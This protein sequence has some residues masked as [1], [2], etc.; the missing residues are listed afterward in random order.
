V[1]SWAYVK[2]L[3]VKG[4][5]TCRPFSLP[6]ELNR[7]FSAVIVFQRRFVLRARALPYGRATAP[8]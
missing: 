5:L 8:L 2:Q 7:M 3:A 1:I 4:G 6:D